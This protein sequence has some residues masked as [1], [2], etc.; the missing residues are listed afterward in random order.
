MDKQIIKEFENQLD[1]VTKMW[2]KEEVPLMLYDSDFNT[3]FRVYENSV[4][5]FGY[6][7]EG[8]INLST[9]INNQRKSE[10]GYVTISKNQLVKQARNNVILKACIDC[11]KFVT[12]PCNPS[13]EFNYRGLR[14]RFLG[15]FIDVVYELK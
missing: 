14:C 8:D 1:N 12:H 2:S 9:R 7:Y 15:Q 6:D 5:G 3:S 10:E 13:K 4:C 11:G